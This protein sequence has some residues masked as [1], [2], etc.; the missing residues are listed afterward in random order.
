[1]G[2]S[3]LLGGGR[4]GGRVGRGGGGG[5]P[6]ERAEGDVLEG[7]PAE[8]AGGLRAPGLAAA[9]LAGQVLGVGAPPQAR[10]WA[11]PVFR[12]RALPRHVL[13]QE[14]AIIGPFQ[15]ARI[16]SLG[17]DSAG[18]LRHLVLMGAGTFG[19]LEQLSKKLGPKCSFSYG[20]WRWGCGFV[21]A[22]K[23]HK[24]GSS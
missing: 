1:M 12:V 21:A 14:V 6:E 8:E 9:L 13:T 19:E 15:E 24:T 18:R 5:A 2:H 3:S 20:L 4:L 17:A 22:T 10:V 11:P 23:V 7:S 16:G